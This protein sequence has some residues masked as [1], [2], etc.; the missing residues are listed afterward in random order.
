MHESLLIK[1]LGPLS[2][3]VMDDIRAVLVLVGAS[4]SGKSLILKVLA[5]MRHVCKRQLIR[6]AMKLSGAK[7][8]SFRL[9]KDSYLRF[10]DIEHLVSNS[11]VVEYVLDFNGLVCSVKYGTAGFSARFVGERVPAEVGPFFKVAFISDTRNLLPS[12]AKKGASLQAKVLDNYFSETYDLWDEAIS[13]KMMT[14][15]RM[16]YLNAQLS[17]RRA[18]NGRQELVIMGKDGRKTNFDRGASGEKSSIPVAIILR[19]LVGGF[20]FPLAIRRSYVNDLLNA[21][22]E[23]GDGQGFLPLFDKEIVAFN[24]RYLCVHVEEPELSLDPETQLRFADELIGIMGR[25]ALGPRNV[26]RSIAFT[27]HSPYWVTAL[28]TIVA[29]RKSSFLT[30]ESI[31]GY[32]VKPDGKVSSLRDE[33]SRLL[34]TPNMDAASLELD[35]RYNIALENVHD[36]D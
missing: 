22:L 35:E 4:G 18:E 3:V 34:M 25:D 10:A 7:K 15:Q 24:S 32:H 13:H 2:N 14:T 6:R 30:W 5:M 31:C 17:I 16:G 1:N 33:E 11:T 28:N 20:D 29:E 26:E 23:H 19:Y 9:R 36:N 12:W 8:T 21:M 27:T